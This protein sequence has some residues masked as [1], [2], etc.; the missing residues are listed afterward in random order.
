MASIWRLGHFALRKP[1]LRSRHAA[2]DRH[3]KTRDQMKDRQN[4]YTYE[5]LLACGRGELFSG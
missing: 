1:M 5:E 4:S 3:A 2:A